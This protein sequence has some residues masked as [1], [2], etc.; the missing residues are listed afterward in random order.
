[1]NASIRIFKYAGV[2]LAS[3]IA[4]TA[5]AVPPQNNQPDQYNKNHNLDHPLGLK[6]A[7]LKA[8]AFEEVLKGKAKGKVHEIAKGQFVELERAGEDLIW[9]ILAEFANLTHN[10]IAEPDRTKDN[11]TIWTVDFSR[12]YF[13]NLLFEGTAGANSMRNYYIEQ[14]SNRY[15]V[16]G[17]VTDWVAVPGIAENYDD[18]LGGAAIWQ[19]LDD[20]AN[21][22]YV[23]QS[24]L[25]GEAAVNSQLSSY[26]IWDRYDYDGDG[27]FN[28]PDGYID[29]FQIVHAGEGE[30]AGGGI[31]GVQAIWSHR[32]YA[33]SSLIGTDGPAGNLAG[34][35]PVGNSGL[36]IGDYTVEPENGGVGVFAHEFA[37][38]LGLPDLYDYAGGSNSTGFWTLMSA[39]SWLNDGTTDIGSMP[40]HMGGWEK[41]QLG[42]YNYEV[43]SAGEHSVHKL[44]PAET[45]TKQ[46]Q[47]VFVVLPDKEVTLTIADPFEGSYFYYSE[48][49]DDLDNVMYLP[50][51][52]TAGSSLTAMVNYDIEVD[53]DYA[54]V[55]V[56]TD[57]GASWLSVPTNH[58]TADNP[59]G[60]NFGSGITGNTA[61]SWMPLTANLSAHEGDVWVGFRYWTDAAVSEPGF[62]AD[63]ISINGGQVFGAEIEEGWQ[64]AGFRTSVGTE[65][66][67]YFNAY[68]AENRIYW[69]YD[70]TLNV[71]PYNFGFLDNSDTF[72]QVEHYPYQDGLLISYW[73]SSF[74]NNNTIQHPGG[75]LILPID[76]HPETMYRSNGSIWQS[77]VHSFDSTFSLEP[78]D[79]I[80]LHWLGVQNFY[81]SQAGNPVFNDLN[82]YWNP[83]TP[84]M[85]VINPHTGTEITIRNQSAKGQ[86]M[87][88]QVSPVK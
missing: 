3:A 44:G 41:F 31:L 9:T 6:Q 42:W 59:N 19:L 21:N 5:L 18:D 76:A 33:Y 68:L 78:T 22:W 60:Q 65:T 43:A 35:V 51:N 4:V 29:H 20:A 1:M 79:A 49:G 56:S 40:G 45:N 17:D 46:A 88:I 72:N 64:M 63:N 38:D 57:S 83:V 34:G 61:D 16:A 71:G 69:G 12:D 75:G 37:H 73:D 50:V 80:S 87:Q 15:T 74:S 55:V 66:S 39:G 52:L 26:D 24:A 13:L 82:Q 62:M 7:A 84:F 2:V 28:E 23:K 58:S 8:R 85:G 86:F 53:W 27:N 25:Y 10:Q 77:R 32:W 81:G 54:Y 14:S 36:W 11:S 70:S 30:E 48:S 47:G 67:F